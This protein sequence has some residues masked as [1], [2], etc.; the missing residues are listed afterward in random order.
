[1]YRTA[2]ATAVIQ[3]TQILRRGLFIYAEQDIS[4]R[5]IDYYLII[6]ITE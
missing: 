3:I 1:M 4:I 6:N 5:F 2:L